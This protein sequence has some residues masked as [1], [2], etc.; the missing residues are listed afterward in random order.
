MT[1]EKTFCGIHPCHIASGCCLL[2]CYLVL[3]LLI[4]VPVVA[5]QFTTPTME[6]NSTQISGLEISTSNATLAVKMQI[7]V[8]NPNSWPYE[9]TLSKLYADVWSLDK[10]GDKGE[11]YMGNAELP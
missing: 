4:A 2:F 5:S 8:K 7:F 1:E 3:G 10:L 6:V 11:Y 9:A